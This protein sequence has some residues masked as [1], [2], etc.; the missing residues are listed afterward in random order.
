MNKHSKAG[1]APKKSYNFQNPETHK[2]AME[3]SAKARKNTT[4]CSEDGCGRL[5]RARGLCPA[6]YEQSRRKRL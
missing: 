5:S 3:N 2:K 1:S 4:V 6:H